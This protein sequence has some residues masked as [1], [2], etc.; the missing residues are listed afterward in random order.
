MALYNYR[1]GLGVFEQWFL[2][3]R[4]TGSAFISQNEIHHVSIAFHLHN[5]L[6]SSNRADT[7]QGYPRAPTSQRLRQTMLGVHEY[8]ASQA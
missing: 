1:N 3:F 7:R 2:F 6:L 4:R 5:G 8:M